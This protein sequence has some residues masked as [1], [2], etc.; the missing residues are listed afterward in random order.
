M[1]KRSPKAKRLI[2]AKR[3]S[4]FWV[5]VLIF[6][7]SV[8]AYWP[9]LQGT[10]LWDDSGHVTPPELQSLQ[11]FWRFWRIWVDRPATQQYYPLLHSAFWIEHQFWGDSVV[12][13]HLTNVLLHALSAC[14]VVMIVRTFR[15]PGAV[16][17]GLIFALHPVC[18]EAV[19]WISEQKST[20][21]GVF[22]LSS[23]LIYLRFEQARRKSLYFLALG[24]FILALLSKTVTATLPAACWSFFGG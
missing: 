21:S 10:L 1:K 12:G 6:C 18:V 2:A 15:R 8:A 4:G 13:Y 7:A 16:L 14:L 17:A 23:A 9:A 22:Y 11:G 20:L 24:L 5:Y 19:A 3:R